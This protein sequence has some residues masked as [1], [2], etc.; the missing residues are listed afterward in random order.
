MAKFNITERRAK[1][2]LNALRLLFIRKGQ[3]TADEAGP[4]LIMDWDWLGTGPAPAIVWEEGPYEWAIERSME[5]QKVI[6]PRV[7]VEPITSWSL[8]IYPA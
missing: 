4:T 6:S 3:L 2:V 5:L 7:F 1:A 8:G